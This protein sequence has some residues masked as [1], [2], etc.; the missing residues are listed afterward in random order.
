MALG[1]LYRGVNLWLANFDKWGTVI[2]WSV[3][4]NKLS[5]VFAYWI[6][7]LKTGLDCYLYH[8]AIN[9]FLDVYELSFLGISEQTKSKMVYTGISILY[10]LV[11]YWIH[12]S[13]Y[14][15]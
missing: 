10:G 15:H 14:Y 8:K 6:N 2:D 5:K 7:R 12:C 11:K 3:C 13:D 4:E 1:G 9:L